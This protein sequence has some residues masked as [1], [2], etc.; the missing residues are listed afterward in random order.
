MENRTRAVGK[1]NELL[2][3]NNDAEK[4]YRE[5]AKNADNSLLQNMLNNEAE[6]RKKFGLKIKDE[7]AKLGGIPE[8]GDSQASK[9]HRTWMDVKAALAPN[10]DDAIVKECERG[11]KNAI[12]EYEEVLKESDL[13]PSSLKLVQQQREEITDTLHQWENFNIK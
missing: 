4:G 1:L 8:K 2:E 7:I 10:T 12:K 3:K 5:A 11:D 9:V 13:T 6:K